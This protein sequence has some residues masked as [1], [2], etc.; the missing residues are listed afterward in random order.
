MSSEVINVHLQ[1]VVGGEGTFAL[2]TRVGI[3]ELAFIDVIRE[4][5]NDGGW[6]RCLDFKWW[7]LV[8]CEMCSE[9]FNW[10]RG[11]ALT[12]ELIVGRGWLCRRAT[13]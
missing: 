1:G 7:V 3:N 4:V 8:A 11:E 9:L 10:E 5:G 2:C 6:L 13:P 12:C